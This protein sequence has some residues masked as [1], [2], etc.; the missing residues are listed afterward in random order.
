LDIRAIILKSNI[1]VLL[2]ACLGLAAQA[3]DPINIPAGVLRVDYERLLPVS[4]LDLPVGDQGFVGAQL[5][6]D[7]NNTTGRFTGHNYTLESRTATPESAIEKLQELEAEGIGIIAVLAEHDELLA[8]ADAASPDTLLINALAPDTDLRSEN[9]RA[10]MLHVVPS[11]QMRADA[12]TQFL[13]WKRWNNWVLLSGSNPK[14][15]LL[16]DAY[17]K[18]AKK[19]G[20]KIVEER[21]IEDEGGARRTDTGHVLVQRQLPILTQNMKDHD[22]VVAADES[23]YFAIYLPYHIWTPSKVTGSAGL[24]P[25]SW[26]P[27]VEAWGATQVQRRFEKLAGRR[28]KEDDYHAWMALRVLGEA[29]TRVGKFDKQSVLDY[30][31]SDD[32]EM[33]AFKGQKANFRLWNGQLRQSMLLGDGRIMVSVSPQDGFLH[34]RTTLDTMGLDEP[35]SKCTAFK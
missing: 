24:M 14:D 25:L 15:E 22:V 31:L 29:V 32:F 30:T 2:L 20:A 27:A 11:R 19:F 10:N 13:I 23:D 16:A 7:D 4:R 12:L 21:V 28:M 34:Q 26:H 5:A 8:L 1:V 9:C 33:A 6:T 17:R 3:K 18:S 35:E